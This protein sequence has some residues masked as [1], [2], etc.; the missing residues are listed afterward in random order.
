V[1]RNFN[2]Y[3]IKIKIKINVLDISVM[4]GYIIS[5][6]REGLDLTSFFLSFFFKKNHGGKIDFKNPNNLL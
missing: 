5:D 1:K 6:L 2:I 3:I 4:I